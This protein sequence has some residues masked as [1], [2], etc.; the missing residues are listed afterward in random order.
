MFLLQ[1]KKP[2][3][4]AYVVVIFVTVVFFLSSLCFITTSSS[5]IVVRLDLAD[6]TSSISEVSPYM[7]ALAR[8][9]FY[10][11]HVY[12]IYYTS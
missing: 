3:K 4:V 12:F 11:F 7:Y 9:L 10:V 6:T 8:H 1:T 5:L 2:Y